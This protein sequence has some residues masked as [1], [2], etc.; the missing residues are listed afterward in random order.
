M[1]DTVQSPA[2]DP[3]LGGG[4]R[5][6]GQDAEQ[7]R[8][9]RREKLLAA[10]LE[11]FGTR[12]YHATTVKQL[13]THAGLTERY[14]YESF[15]TREE[16]LAAIAGDITEQAFAA[17]RAAVAAAGP[18]LRA[19]AYGGVSAY[20]TAVA[21]DRRCGRVHLLEILTVS[22]ELEAGRRATLR[23]LAGEITAALRAAGAGQLPDGLDLELVALG[24][25][26][27]GN[28]LL[29]DWLLHDDPEPLEVVIDHVMVFYE[30][31]IALAVP[32]DPTRCP[33][34]DR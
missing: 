9:G 21:G 7:R 11:L 6:G 8:R 23:A 27:A 24:V 2:V 32:A 18:D 29:A 20:V 5:Y 30:Q 22:P 12:G 34:C 28:E 13:C 17:L 14:F 4:R 16:L 19:Q 25:I 10:G 1:S 3:E 26:G 15:R 33:V 31:L